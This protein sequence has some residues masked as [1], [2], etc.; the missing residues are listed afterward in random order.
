M[1]LEKLKY[2]TIAA[3]LAVLSACDGAPATN[4]P[5]TAVQIQKADGVE[6][7]LTSVEEGDS[8]GPAG[9]IPKA[10]EGAVYVTAT[11]TLKNTSDSSFPMDKWPQFKLQDGAGKQ[12]N[13][14]LFASTAVSAAANPSWA[15]TL[16]P[17]LSTEAR[18][19]WRIAKTSFD[20]KTWKMVS[21]KPAL[22]FPLK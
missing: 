6:V 2:A 14:E 9:L 17:G 11:Y 7:T 13:P 10:G 22:T 1:Y 15:E 16:N 8:V 5:G 18:L 12:L 19:V 21:A 20:R 4:A 3:S